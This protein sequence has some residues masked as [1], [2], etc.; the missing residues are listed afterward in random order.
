MGR[1]YVLLDDFDGAELPDDTQ[2][3]NLSIGRQTYAVYLSDENYGKLLQAIDPF[4]KDAERVNAPGRGGAVP[5]ASEA[6]KEKL[7]KVREWA[8]STKYTYTNAKG[9]E[10]TLGDR[11]R[12]P[13]EVIDAYD[14][15]N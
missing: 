6:E 14:K 5:K 12:I 13:Q 15:A 10:T 9:E 4:I 1:K 2:P 8:Q 3:V 7:R 11:G